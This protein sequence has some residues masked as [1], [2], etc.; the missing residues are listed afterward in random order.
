MRYYPG[1]PS[2]YR[3]PSA[4]REDTSNQPAEGSRY[5]NQVFSVKDGEKKLVR[6]EIYECRYGQTK[7]GKRRKRPD[8]VLI[9]T[10]HH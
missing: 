2:K 8:Y 3:G 4:H 6:E 1:D 10:I 7:S 5:V 9:E